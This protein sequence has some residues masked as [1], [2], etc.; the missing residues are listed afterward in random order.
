MGI[1]VYLLFIAICKFTG[2]LKNAVLYLSYF[3]LEIYSRDFSL[4]NYMSNKYIG[5]FTSYW[6]SGETSI[7]NITSKL[8]VSFATIAL[9]YNIYKEL[10]FYKDIDCFLQK[11]GV[12]SLAIYCLHWPF[13]NVRFLSPSLPRK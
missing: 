1:C 10:R 2:Q 5:L 11:L 13:N 6:S 3:I 7:M 8:I 12:Y 4:L 9:V